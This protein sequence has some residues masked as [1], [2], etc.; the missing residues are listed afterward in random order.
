M[1]FV[2]LNHKY[3]TCFKSGSN[4]VDEMNIEKKIYFSIRRGTESAE[5]SFKFRK[6]L[7]WPK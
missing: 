6:S 4:F 1:G 3:N 7:I 5:N 2:C